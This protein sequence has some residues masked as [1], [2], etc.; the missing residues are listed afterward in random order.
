MF[1][2]ASLICP[3][4]KLCYRKKMCD[5]MSNS[6]QL[7]FEIH[8]TRHTETLWLVRAGHPWMTSR[9]SPTCSTRNSLRHFVTGAVG[10]FPVRRNLN[11]WPSVV[12]SDPVDTPAKSISVGAMSIFKII[13]CKAH[14][15]NIYGSVFQPWLIDWLIDLFFE[16]EPVAAI[17]MLT[18]PMAMSA[19]RNLSWGGHRAEIRGQRLRV[20]KGK[21]SSPITPSLLSAFDLELK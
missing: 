4:I 16:V 18:K 7:Y 1:S 2:K 3:C 8:E 11:D 19:A 5:F 13:S 6:M 14:I 15:V 21:D 12:S 10:E 20:G 9:Y 17:L